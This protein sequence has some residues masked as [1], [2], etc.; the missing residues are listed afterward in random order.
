MDNNVRAYSIGPPPPE[1][2]LRLHLNEFRHEHSAWV[3]AAAAAPVAARD[4]DLTRYPSGALEAGLRRA[5]VQYLDGGDRLR[6]PDE[7]KMTPEHVLLA[8]GS[9]EV[10]RA[11]INTSGLRGHRR[12][13]M[14]VP[15]Y[16]HF[17]HYARLQG[18]EVVAVPLGLGARDAAGR[19]LE[20][21]ALESALRYYDA[22]L[23]EGCLVYLCSPNN[24]TGTI[25]T[26]AEV[27]R[28]AGDFPRSL[29]LVD[30]A[31][32]EFAGHE[33][34]DQRRTAAKLGISLELAR[35]TIYAGNAPMNIRS[36]ARYAIQSRNVVVSRTMSKVFGLAALRVGYAVGCPDV[37]RRVGIAVSPKSMGDHSVR[38]ATAAL[39]GASH[40]SWYAAALMAS[41]ERLCEELRA[42]DWWVAD[43]PANFFLV[44]V[45]DTAAAVAALAAA[46]VQVRD[47][48]DQPGLA[49]FVRL[50]A[51]TAED[52]AAVLA[53][54]R[55][56]TPPTGPPPQ[57]LYTPKERVAE[58]KTMMRRTVLALRDCRVEFWA[59][60]GTMLGMLR[61]GGMIPTDD[62]GDLAYRRG[63]DGHDPLA[64]CVEAFRERGLTLQR[65]RTDAYWQVGTNEP[66]AT[67]SPVHVD[68]F[69]Y[70]LA[71]DPV[72][73]AQRYLLD[74]VR[75]REEDPASSQAHCNTKYT[76]REL[77][78]LV[79]GFRFY[80]LEIPM[81]RESE[82]VLRRALG[83]D[84][85]RVMR[86]RT[87]A[88]VV[89]V[90]L[91]DF[92]AA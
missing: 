82:A 14:G 81:P 60:S 52:G 10:L 38:I 53:A 22:M 31:Y 83:E 76:P 23:R 39:M 70:R 34:A 77:F 7:V 74:D 65:N 79:D 90:P 89:E 1:G 18:L 16:T 73:G 67:I 84:C 19:S 15:S 32:I 8:A 3:R 56:L 2:V 36:L 13:L 4:E 85:L 12:V 5:L 37:I 91:T 62:D 44:Y 30:E 47:R 6:Y 25:W 78:P 66:G 27:E 40:Y 41:A 59:Q 9:D 63:E 29:F 51:G 72:D 11:V 42:L 48:G 28:L 71:V 20:R 68:L 21:R 26:Q 69:S 92:T 64:G 46:G 24:P 58:I 57:T 45:G 55:G 80:D 54:F 86:V 33:P 75:F 35:N 61:H 88:G 87:P 49:G 17:E 50:T 43:T